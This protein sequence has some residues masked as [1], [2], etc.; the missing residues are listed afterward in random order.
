MPEA[1]SAPIPS[2]AVS[3]YPAIAL[4]LNEKPKLLD[5]LREALRSRHYSPRPDFRHGLFHLTHVDL[6]GPET[7]SPHGDCV[8][9]KEKGRHSRENG[10]PGNLKKT[11]LLKSYHIF[12]RPELPGCPPTRA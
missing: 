3:R 11:K 2:N 10:N 8:A 12:Q 4:R 9:I 1:N 5:R 7:A 6:F